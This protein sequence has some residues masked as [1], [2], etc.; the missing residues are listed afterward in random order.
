MIFSMYEE[1]DLRMKLDYNRVRGRIMNSDPPKSVGSD[2]DAS[3]SR[4]WE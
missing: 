4:S 3:R 2:V 1:V